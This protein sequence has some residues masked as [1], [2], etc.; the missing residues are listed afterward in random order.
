MI[1][2]SSLTL[3]PGVFPG[4]M[5]SLRSIR[6]RRLLGTV[7]G[8]RFAVDPN[9]R[10]F[11]PSFFSTSNHPK[12]TPGKIE[13]TFLEDSSGINGVIPGASSALSAI[14]RALPNTTIPIPNLPRSPIELL[15]DSTPLSDSLIDHNDS[16]V[17]MMLVYEGLWC[18][19][20]DN[21]RNEYVCRHFTEEIPQYYD[22][23]L[24]FCTDSTTEDRILLY[25]R[26]K[27]YRAMFNNL[28]PPGLYV[29]QGYKYRISPI[30]NKSKI[31]NLSVANQDDPRAASA[32]A[33]SK[34]RKE[35]RLL[36]RNFAT[37]EDSSHKRKLLG[38]IRGV[39]NYIRL[40][41]HSNSIDLLRSLELSKGW[42]GSAATI[43]SNME[44]E[45]ETGNYFDVGELASKRQ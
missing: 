4:R 21:A 23:V 24:Q 41:E 43:T 19:L 17:A 14:D 31:N 8:A 36:D 22:N 38:H 9:R 2:A 44:R 12:F 45:L 10:P 13:H 15:R 33:Y 32:R 34:A 27:I 3:L 25:C 29:S 6:P 39:I 7:L 30:H 40:S 18:D 42:R 11:S 37:P 20:D 16:D 5:L 28:P 26:S 1:L 35:I